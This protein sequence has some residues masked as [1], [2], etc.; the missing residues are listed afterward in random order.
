[1]IPRF[2]TKNIH[3]YL[4]YPVAISL[5]AL[6]FVL[7]LGNSHPVALWLS[8]VTGIAAFFLTVLTDHHLGVF[9]VLPYK[10]HLSVD[11]AVGALFALIP[12]ILSFSGIDAIYYWANGLAV[13]IV[14]GL[15]KPEETMQLA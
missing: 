1:M 5:I 9:R 10:F 14:V 4:D 12:F 8:V 2:V 13:L 7:G 3:A 15:H 11:F 6:P